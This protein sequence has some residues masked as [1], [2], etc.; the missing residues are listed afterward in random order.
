M[1]K[2]IDIRNYAL[3]EALHIDFHAGFSVITGE[4]GAGKSIILGAIGLLLGQRADVKA[5]KQGQSKCVVEAHFDLTGYGLEPFFDENE[6]DYDES[7]CIV[8]R[9]ILTMGKSR[10]FIND[11][12]VAL[13]VLKALGEQLIDVHSQHQNLL[14]S[15]SGFQL[16]TLDTL[17]DG[18]DEL[19]N[20]K[21]VFTAF[22]NL[23]KQLDEMQ[24]K[25]AGD[26]EE[27]DFLQF[28]YE[29]LNEAM[30]HEGEQ[31]GL[32]EEAN[33][34]NHTEEIKSALCQS[35]AGLES[36]SG[37]V[38]TTLKDILQSLQTVRDHYPTCQDWTERMNSCYI[39]LK[40][41]SREIAN[42][43][44]NIDYDPNRLEQVNERLDL[45]Y[46]LE[47]KHRVESVEQLMDICRQLQE[48]LNLIQSGDEELELLRKQH[49]AL[50]GELTVLGAKLTK[51]RIQAAKSMQR[52]MCELLAPLGM[53]NVRFEV[54]VTPY[55]TPRPDGMDDVS[56][57][58]S[59]NKNAPLQDIVSVASG[60]EIAR[61]MLSLKTLIANRRQL[62]T[63]IFDEIDTGVSGP[64]AERMA[65]LMKQMGSDGR[66]VISITHLPQIAARGAAHYKVYKVDTK[67]D[68][69]TCIKELNK[70]ERITEI[71][72]M[73]SGATLT[74]AALK[75]AQALLDN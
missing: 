56:F 54:Q 48:R 7:E 45:I 61:V 8:R 47:K 74:E 35:Q 16:A 39:D 23:E 13:A 73:L 60:G 11:V 5:I 53:P 43:A 28:Q 34:L 69:S 67:D 52:R 14:L 1:L 71:A 4:T 59:A 75:N 50:S 3:I 49:D 2:T 27:Q 44:D 42:A 21:Q 12:P 65:M 33:L 66:Q 68:T 64:I 19:H 32:E 9:E 29:Q 25:I 62:P 10:A 17:S 51:K 57:M 58:F 38:L 46:S 20:Y 37:G 41:L 55:D 22:R 6:L 26:K 30:L 15:H 70:N 36:E 18:G 24:M 63:I 31:T 40:E 72:N